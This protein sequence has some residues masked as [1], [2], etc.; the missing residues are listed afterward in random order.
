MTLNTRQ[1]YENIQVVNRLFAVR[2]ICRVSKNNDKFNQVKS[3]LYI[4]VVSF[5]SLLEIGCDI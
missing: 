5:L 2:N 4:C 3:W 1:M